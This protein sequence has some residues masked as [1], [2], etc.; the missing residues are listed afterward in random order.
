MNAQELV[1]KLKWRYAVKKFDSSK[2]ISQPDLEA[3][4]QGLI[5]SPSSYGLQPWKFL[6]IQNPEIRK[7]LRTHSWNQSQVEEASH[8]VVICNLVQLDETYVKKFIKQMALQR[9]LAEQSM[10]SYEEM[11]IQNVAQ[12]GQVKDVT[13]WAAKQCYIALGNL[14]NNAAMLGIDSCPL[15]GFDPQK[16]NEILKLNTTAY[17]SA[18][19]C[20]IG[21]RSLEDNYALAQ[22][23]R[24]E[25]KDLIEVY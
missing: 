16:Y 7:E 2:K 17:R 23:V 21:Y 19:A 1:E 10:K 25:E 22:K 20:A 4:K 13:T 3:L 6:F 5:L 9:G 14:M 11:M 8:F 15:E 18:V 24:F 12:G